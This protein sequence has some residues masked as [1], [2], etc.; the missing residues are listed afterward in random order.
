M[1][2]QANSQVMNQILGTL[3]QVK[4]DRAERDALTAMMGAEGPEQ[5]REVLAT[6]PW[7][8]EGGGVMGVLNTFNPA[9]ASGQMTQIERSA[10]AG[11]LKNMLDSDAGLDSILKQAQIENLGARTRRADAE[12]QL[13]GG[14][15]GG[16]GGGGEMMLPSRFNQDEVFNA[17]MSGLPEDTRE[18]NWYGDDEVYGKHAYRIGLQRFIRA[19]GKEGLPAGDSRKLF[20]QMWQE[21][22]LLEADQSFQKYA[23]PRSIGFPL[24]DTPTVTAGP[25]VVKARNASH[26]MTLVRAGKSL[27]EIDISDLDRGEQMKLRTL[28]QEAQK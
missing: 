13:Y 7:A 23:D 19:A 22:Y 20:N 3:D 16:A 11:I 17:A 5:L 28:I 21:K 12:A 18:K 15:L 8:P 25:G 10:G 6:R 14:G 1:N 24:D 4:R 9:Q 27:D 2:M 26:A